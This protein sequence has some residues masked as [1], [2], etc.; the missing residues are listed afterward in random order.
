MNNLNKEPDVKIQNSI[1]TRGELTG[2]AKRRLSLINKE[3]RNAFEFIS[4]FKKSV[5]IFGS[6]RVGLENPHYISALN[7]AKRLSE[8]G[9]TIVTGGGPGIMEAANRGAFEAGGKSVGLTIELPKRQPSN[10]FLTDQMNFHYFFTR[11]E[12]LSFAAEAYIF[13]PG[14]FGTLD[15]F[16]EI[17]TLVQTRKIRP[18]P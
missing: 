6:T 10:E 3:F 14:G 4:H 17:I 11:K 5:T 9:Y 12:A 2:A 15:E 1:L 16:F 8:L 7:L 13:Y 18:V